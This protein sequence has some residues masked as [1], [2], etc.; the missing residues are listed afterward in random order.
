MRSRVE[1]RVSLENV[2]RG[3]MIAVLAIM[4][5]QSLRQQPD[6]GGGTVSARGLGRAL[7]E[8]S[9]FGKAPVTIQVQF[10]SLPSPRERAWLGALGVGSTVLWSGDVLPVMIQARS[11][12]SPA[13]GTRVVAAAPN[14]SALVVSDQVGMI[15]TVDA[16]NHGAWLLLG[17]VA[18]RV[19][20][21][22][23]G[24]VASTVQRDSL[25]VHK[26]L[27]IG[28]AGW[29]LK[30]VVAALE[31]DNWKVDA[32]VR[33]APGV[34]VT[35]SSLATID[36]SH[37]SVVVALDDAATT[38][39]NRIADFARKGGGV[40]LAS[41][42]ASLGAMAA[43]RVG[44]AGR[45]IAESPRPASGTATLATLPFVPI[46]SLRS[47]AV[48]LDKR[49]G[50]VAVAARRVGT[51]LAV[52]L[53][54][55]TTWRWRM[56]GGDEG[57]RDHRAWWTGLVSSVVHAP[58]LARTKATASTDEAPM[59]GLVAAIGPPTPAAT[60]ATLSGAQIEWMPWLFVLLTLGLFVEAASRRLRGAP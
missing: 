37:Y 30:F 54:Y 21:G 59:I 2:V 50:S 38:Y 11:V 15:D 28:S 45:T 52:Q 32:I 16:Q 46:T 3:I 43:L 13:G 55:E 57:V 26:V 24:S 48:P 44:A 51:G 12:A 1:I 5:W 18:G 20:A 10:D 17:S 53:G 31:E 33:I 23:N 56:T 49:A 22:V 47:D 4:L 6:S 29:E 42:A 36:T 39:A 60:M 34:D 40:V 41:H 7:R 35:Q 8:W 58:H 27:V 25:V 9:G 19:T 14:G